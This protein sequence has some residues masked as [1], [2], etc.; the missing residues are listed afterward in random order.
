MKINI[1]YK[2]VRKNYIFYKNTQKELHNKQKIILVNR[3]KFIDI[4]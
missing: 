4:I 3:I 1:Y 2:S